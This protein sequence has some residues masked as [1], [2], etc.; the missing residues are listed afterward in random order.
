MSVLLD[1]IR[2]YK[3]EWNSCIADSKLLVIKKLVNTINIT[4]HNMNFLS[5]VID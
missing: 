4:L 1:C 2:V 5:L 3:M